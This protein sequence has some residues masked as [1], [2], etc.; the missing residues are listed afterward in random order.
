[1]KNDLKALIAVAVGLT[2][3][4]AALRPGTAPAGWTDAGANGQ[5]S[6][7][8]VAGFIFGSYVLPFEILSVLLLVALVGAIML[9]AKEPERGERR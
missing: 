4:F 1:M 2:M 5:E 7:P 6:V 8:G 3:A 9:A